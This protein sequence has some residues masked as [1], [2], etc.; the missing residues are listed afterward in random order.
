MHSE[1]HEEAVALRDKL[2]LF[3]R[4]E[5]PSHTS[6]TLV[7][8]ETAAVFALLAGESVDEPGSAEE[9]A[10]Y[11]RITVFSDALLEYLC[12]YWDDPCPSRARRLRGAGQALDAA[13]AFLRAEDEPPCPGIAAQNEAQG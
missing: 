3:L 4:V 10:L 8:K 5:N 13:E 1:W 11:D 9:R 7:R 2:R 12:L 6:E